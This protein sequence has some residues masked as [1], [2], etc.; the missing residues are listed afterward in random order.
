M[1]GWS[2]EPKN[3][4]A[5]T[6]CIQG[7]TLKAGDRVRIWPQKNADIMDLAMKGKVAIVEA[8]ERDLEDQTHIAVV[9]EDDPGREFGFLRQPG[10]RFFFLPEEV[11]P[12]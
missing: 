12:L 1:D 4:S 9:L 10:H 3:V 6:V 2:Q 5:E 11:E 7:V 8:I